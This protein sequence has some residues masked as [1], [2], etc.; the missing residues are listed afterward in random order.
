MVEKFNIPNL[1][2]AS[3]KL[4]D[5][6]SKVNDTLNNVISN[7]DA[8]AST[9]AS[10]L[11]SNITDVQSKVKSLVPEMPALPNIN[12][13]S[14]LSSLSSLTAGLPQ[15]TELLTKITSDFGSA[16]TSSGFSLDT[17]VSQASSAF[18]SSTSLSGLVPNFEKAADGLSEPFEKA[19]AT[20]LPEVEAIKEELSTLNTNE[21]FTKVIS[22][23]KTLLDK[24]KTST[25]LPTTNTGLFIPTTKSNKVV[26]DDYRVK[27]LEEYQ[28]K[29]FTD[30]DKN[31]LGS[32][33]TTT[34]AVTTAA[35]A[36]LSDGNRAN[37]S[38][39]GFA[40]KIIK[41]TEFF[42]SVGTS[43]TLKREPTR[44]TAV[45]GYTTKYKEG[46]TSL[47]ILPPFLA[48]LGL[49]DSY[50]VDGKTVTIENKKRTYDGHPDTGVVY[51]VN[52][53]YHNDYDAEFVQGT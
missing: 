41:T 24:Y 35:N 45:H 38:K 5:I 34:K 50:S 11:T 14:Q 26:F 39:D 18:G 8:D 47:Q 15:H 19:M 43:I 29:T 21:S 33:V 13:Q 25:S 53:A 6:Q 22:E 49:F 40:N 37:I 48:I 27:V 7:I 44:V 10:A 20:R 17:L 28:P 31:M 1:A 3:A 42:K 32:G 9:A 2:G 52:Y 51:V 30:L 46:K 36:I 23:R 4:N 16:L 12:L